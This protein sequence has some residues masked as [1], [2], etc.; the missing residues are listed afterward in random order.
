MAAA[1]RN[2]TPLALE[3]GGKSPNIVFPDA[4]LDAAA[5]M[6]AVVGTALLSG[7]G[8]ALPTRLY[9]HDDVYDEV[10]A[11]VWPRSARSPWAT[12]STRPRSS[13]PSSPRRPWIG[14]WQ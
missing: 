14:S 7:Q 13:V 6:A 2:L 3:L 9:V 1:A 8:C 4:D 12:R 11:K 5:T 10:V